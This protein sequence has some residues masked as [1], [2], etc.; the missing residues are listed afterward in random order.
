ME[1]QRKMEI[2]N[3]ERNIN[4]YFFENQ[5]FP[6]VSR[7]T[8]N[9]VL[10][11][12][13]CPTGVGDSVRTYSVAIMS[14]DDD[15]HHCYKFDNEYLF[16]NMLLNLNC[17][18][19]NIY[20]HNLLYDIKP[21]LNCFISR[22]NAIQV[23]D[24]IVER[25]VKN[26]LTGTKEKLNVTKVNYK[27]EY[28]P[29]QFKVCLKKGQLYNATFYGNYIEV[30]KKNKKVNKPIVINWFDTLKIAPFSLQKCCSD[31]LDLKLPKDGLDY[32]KIREY[33][34]QLTNEE[35]VY[36][37]ND[38]FG[39]SELVK[40]LIINGFWI[41][42]K[43]VQYTK[44]TNSSQSLSDYKDTLL[45]DYLNKQNAF[46]DDDFYNAVDSELQL[47]YM[48]FFT[49]DDV[50]KQKN[51]LFEVVFPKQNYYVDKFIRNSYYGGLS[52]VHFDNVRKY[53]KYENKIGNVYDVNSLYPFIMKTKLLPVGNGVYSNKPYNQMSKIRRKQYPLYIQ[54]I[55][56]YDMKIKPNKMAFVQVKGDN[57][58]NGRE[59]IEENI[60]K[61]GEKQV[62][63]LT[64]CN[65]LLELLFE[66]YDV[67]SYKFGG[68]IA[69]RG[70]HNIFENYINYWANIKKRSTGSNRAIAKLRLNSLYG[71][72]GTSGDTEQIEIKCIN[73]KFHVEHSHKV[74]VSDNIYVAMS[75]FITSYAKQYLVDAINENY[76]KFLYCDT[77]SLHL[78]GTDCKGLNLDSKE[79]GSWD[80]ELTFDDFKYIGSKRYAER[81]IK[82]KKWEIKC[83]GLSDKIMK[84]VDDITTFDNCEYSTKELKKIK[85]FTKEN[86]VYYYKD[87][88]CTIKVIGLYKSQKSKIVEGGTN[89]IEQPYQIMNGNYLM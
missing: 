55:T 80:N 43:K 32:N 40:K 76:D 79:F 77:D 51:I 83:C 1:L 14:C 25:E 35:K 86:D 47:K 50:E 24:D 67:K 49:C 62:I 6:I 16:M 74:L 37:Y 85:L 73:N 10:D 33:G 75:S 87:E 23:Y 54:E 17:E 70:T 39:L 7:E 27:A 63:K 69:F 72:F 88:K 58:F 45:E 8:I 56:I 12:E 48:K 29:N 4:Y 36:I 82:T 57:N 34:E 53:E 26:P 9:I 64:L 22:Y 78:F 18:T 3:N 28:E 89:I 38:V 31:F 59:I 81:N 2:I 5:Q 41:D 20:V 71:K 65:P 42:G 61:Y 13:A 19:V 11:I 84:Q 66:N 21:F 44:L 60:N 46:S 52:T 30:K 15:T 68:H